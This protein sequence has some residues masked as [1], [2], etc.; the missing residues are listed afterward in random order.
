MNLAPADVLMSSIGIRNAP[1][2]FFIKPITR[3]IAARVDASYLTENIKT[4]F[5]FLEQQLASSPQNGEFFAGPTFTGADAMMYFPLELSATRVGA[6]KEKYPKIHAYIER[7]QARPAYQQA[8]KRIEQ[9]T[10][11]KFKSVL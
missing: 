1:V 3:G 8:I 4:Q 5:G 2:P 11:E 6:T 9:V 7:I 10:G